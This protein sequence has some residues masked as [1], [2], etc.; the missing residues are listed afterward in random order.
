MTA[1]SRRGRANWS[2]GQPGQQ[3]NL[4]AE[5]TSIDTCVNIF[6]GCQWFA[7]DDYR[8]NGT[9][10]EQLE[11]SSHVSPKFF[12]VRQTAVRDAVPKR[13]TTTE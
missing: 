6:Y 3:Y 13:T 12:R 11:Q 1:E 4:A 9:L 2:R 10:A 7:S 5:P 8:M